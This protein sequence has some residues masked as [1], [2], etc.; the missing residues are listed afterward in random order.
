MI[1]TALH[2][3]G[4]STI[5]KERVEYEEVEKDPDHV[6]FIINR[7]KAKWK[8][9][10]KYR[11]GSKEVSRQVAGKAGAPSRQIAEGAGSCCSGCLENNRE[12]SC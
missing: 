11:A 9:T 1:T 3:L 7:L 10:K 2:F 12:G 5:V 6:V 8:A 4:F